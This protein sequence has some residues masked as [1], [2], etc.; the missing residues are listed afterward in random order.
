[1]TPKN[2][3]VIVAGQANAITI[4]TRDA[5][6][7]K[8][9]V[10]LGQDGT[11]Q[12]QGRFTDVA[13]G[14]FV[15]FGG[16]GVSD[17]KFH[18]DSNAKTLQKFHILYTR[19]LV[20]ASLI[21]APSCYITTFLHVSIPC[22]AL[23]DTL[24]GPNAQ[25]ETSGMIQQRGI[26]AKSSYGKL[27][28]NAP[29]CIPGNNITFAGLSVTG[30]GF[31]QW[32]QTFEVTGSIC[33]PVSG[34]VPASGKPVQSA[35]SSQLPPPPPPYRQP[36]QA[37]QAPGVPQLPADVGASTWAVTNSLKTSS[38]SPNFP[39]VITATVTQV[40]ETFTTVYVAA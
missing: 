35:P 20:S 22:N 30:T 12:R 16:C 5:S 3:N 7:L 19:I 6:Q 29:N 36:T 26:T 15:P 18:A 31:G 1:V 33:A 14:P 2:G 28:F 21:R 32:L 8:G 39:G 34:G 27:V 17:D 23:V 4:S 11:G 38:V 9:A 25:G 13:G 37:P 40:T 24:V 10:I